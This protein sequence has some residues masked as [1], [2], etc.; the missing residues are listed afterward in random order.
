[1][2]LQLLLKNMVRINLIYYLFYS[3]L[4]IAET[5]HK[6]SLWFMVTIED[7]CSVNTGFTVI[8]DCH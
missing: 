1:M 6:F 5:V 4:I 2:K 8:Q 3:E 7:A